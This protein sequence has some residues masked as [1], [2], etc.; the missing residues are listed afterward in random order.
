MNPLQTPLL[1][2]L[3][4]GTLGMAAVQNAGVVSP[5]RAQPAPIQTQ[6]TNFPGI[7]AELIECK[8]KDGVL[9]IRIR[10]RNT[11]DKDQFIQ[12]VNSSNYDPYY[13]TAG[14]KKYFILRDAEKAPLAPYKGGGDYSVTVKKGASYTWWAKYPAPP[15]D[16]K[17]INYFTPFGSPFDDVPISD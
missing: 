5:A 8:R 10:L 14:T 15:A 7:T 3:I 6:E 17:K 16:V 9:T 11:S 1:P 2:L 4:A 13:F 12:L